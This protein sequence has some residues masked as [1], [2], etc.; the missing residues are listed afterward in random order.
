MNCMWMSV[1]VRPFAPIAQSLF[2]MSPRSTPS[3][4]AGGWGGGGTG[5][6]P[7]LPGPSAPQGGDGH[8]D[9]EGRPCRRRGD[10]QPGEAA[11]PGHQDRP[12]RRQRQAPGV[13]SQRGGEGMWA[14][15]SGSSQS[16]PHTETEAHYILTRSPFP[17]TQSRS[18]P[19]PTAAASSISGASA[20]AKVSRVTGL[21]ILTFGASLAAV[22]H[23]STLFRLIYIF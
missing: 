19:R 6:T 5:P 11:P 8:G 20:A 2:F 23:P 18:N 16:R 10:R 14:A 4:L 7:P 3:D 15:T 21:N 12:L 13:I 22:A 1:V 9:T 17:L